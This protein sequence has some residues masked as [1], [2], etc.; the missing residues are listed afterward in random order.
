M[1]KRK[2]R[3]IRLLPSLQRS[4]SQQVNIMESALEC[5]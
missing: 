2:G 5:M 1:G 3:V 4:Y